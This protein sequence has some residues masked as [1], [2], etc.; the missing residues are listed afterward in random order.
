MVDERLAPVSVCLTG[1]NCHYSHYKATGWVWS[2]RCSH[3]SDGENLEK[4]NSVQRPI[5]QGD[6]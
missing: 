1:A 6:G 5:P 4:K 2:S 3:Y